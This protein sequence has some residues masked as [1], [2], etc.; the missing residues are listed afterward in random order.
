MNHENISESSTK[1]GMNL[2]WGARDIAGAINLNIRQTF[3][4]LETG[5]IPAKKVG[6]KWVAERG[7]LRAFFLESAEGMK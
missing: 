2:I 1:Q 3:Y 7:A 6:G 4:A 5:A